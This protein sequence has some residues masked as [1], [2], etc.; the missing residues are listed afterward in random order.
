MVT[1]LP[2]EGSAPHR[3]ARELQAKLPSPHP[4]PNTHRFGRE[5]AMEEN[6]LVPVTFDRRK[7]C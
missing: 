5:Q 1:Q 7:L 6:R 3:K 2:W 4:A